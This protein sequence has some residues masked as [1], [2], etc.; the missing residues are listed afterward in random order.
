M[1][2]QVTFLHGNAIKL[3]IDNYNDATNFV[4]IMQA[5]WLDD[6]IIRGPIKVQTLSSNQAGDNTLVLSPTQ[7]IKAGDLVYCAGLSTFSFVISIE[8]IFQTPTVPYVFCDGPYGP[9][10]VHRLPPSG[11]WVSTNVQITPSLDQPMSLASFVTFAAGTPTTIT[12]PQTGSTTRGVP[13]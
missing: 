10:T 12:I 3:A 5:N 8:Q 1:D 9:N 11:Q 4:Q 2:K 7:D 13:T 6:W